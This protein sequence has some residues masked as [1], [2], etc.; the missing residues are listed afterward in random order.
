MPGLQSLSE[1]SFDR[2]QEDSGLGSKGSWGS[3]AASLRSNSMPNKTKEGTSL[4][5]IDGGQL[6]S[7]LW[8]DGRGPLW[9][10]TGVWILFVGRVSSR[11]SPTHLDP[12][13]FRRPVFTHIPACLQVSK[14]CFSLLKRQSSCTVTVCC[15]SYWRLT[16]LSDCQSNGRR[17]NLAEPGVGIGRERRE[18]RQGCWIAESFVCLYIRCYIWVW[19]KEVLY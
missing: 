4:H 13:S 16:Y 11:E 1:S 18:G 6:C 10:K 14:Y 7:I 15:Y 19:T 2:P 8:R 17:W 3:L 12:R 9:K 5:K